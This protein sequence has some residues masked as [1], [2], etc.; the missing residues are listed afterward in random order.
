MNKKRK[1]NPSSSLPR[2][3]M[4]NNPSNHVQRPIIIFP[5]HDELR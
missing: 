2:S 4:E 1:V 5:V 3:R